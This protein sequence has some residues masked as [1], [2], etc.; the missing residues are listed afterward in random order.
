MLSIGF[1]KST[2]VQ[3]ITVIGISNLVGKVVLS[4]AGQ[5]IPFP[6][7]FLLIISSVINICVMVSLMFS[8]TVIPMYCVAVG[9]CLYTGLLYRVAQ[10]KQRISR[11]F[12]TL[13]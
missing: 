11:F 10:K 5:Y 1:Q 3:V 13:L 6:K 12:R 7:V 2:A 4:L 8:R 9:K